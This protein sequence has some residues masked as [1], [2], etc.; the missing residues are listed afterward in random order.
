MTDDIITKKSDELIVELTK[1]YV[2]QQISKI[3][4]MKDVLEQVEKLNDENK[5]KLKSVA[6]EQI[7]KRVTDNLL[8]KYGLDMDT[9]SLIGDIAK[10]ACLASKGEIDVNK[11]IAIGGEMAPKVGK[12]CKSIFSC[13]CGDDGAKEIELEKRV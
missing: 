1:K 2:G 7:F 5:E 9:L 6:K 11:I 4:I 3:G 8:K 12:C 10:I 13:C